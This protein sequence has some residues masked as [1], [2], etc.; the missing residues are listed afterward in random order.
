MAGVSFCGVCQMQVD[1]VGLV[2]R[3]EVVL[4][5]KD[6]SV[7]ARKRF[8]NMI[9]TAGKNWF[10]NYLGAGS[11]PAKMS[12]IAIGT[13]TTTP[14]VGNTALVTETGTRVS[15][16]HSYTG[17]K[18]KMVGTFGASNPTTAQAI[19]ESGVFNASSGGTMLCRQTFAAINKGTADSLE[20]TWEI[21]FS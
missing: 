19:T 16:A 11:P 3:V 1:G 2:G 9:V 21:T 10:A 4:R 12:H 7:K 13:G 18:W 15:V 8:R 17:A 5:D 6:G 20:I 14:A